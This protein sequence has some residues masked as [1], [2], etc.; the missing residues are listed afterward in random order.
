MFDDI[1]V[2][3][4]MEIMSK[5][6]N[7]WISEE[8]EM[9]DGDYKIIRTSQSGDVYQIHVW[10][11]NEGKM[12]RRSL[13][14]KHLE[15][16]KEKG[17]Q[18]YIKIMSLVNNGK[19]VFSDDVTTVVNR[20]IQYR[21]SDVDTGLIVKGRLTTIHTHLKH[22]LSY[23][24]GDMR[25]SDIHRGTFKE[26]Y[27]FRKKESNNTVNDDT[28]RN[29]YS[30]IR[31]WW[32]YVYDTG[33]TSMTPDQLEFQKFKRERLQND[34]RRDTFTEEEYKKFYTSMRTYCSKKEC[35]TE[36][37]YYNREILRNYTLILSNTGMRTGELDQLKWEDL[38]DYRET[39]FHGQVS[40]IVKIRVRKETSKVRKTRDLFCRESKYFH[41]ISEISK[42]KGNDDFIFCHYDGNVI[43]PRQKSE[44]WNSV[45]KISGIKSEG[46]KLSFYSLRHYFVTQRWKSGV[47]LRD[48][49]NSCGTSVYQLEKTYY[50]IDEETMINTVMYDKRL[51]GKYE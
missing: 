17:K 15:T 27:K 13:R 26:Y 20:F 3:F 24:H 35:K 49:A 30:S 50:H 46:R 1:S 8:H 6:V 29:E 45:I 32:K 14:T 25:V 31:Q 22:M 33:L 39:I 5:R 23:L 16:A 2:F 36:K 47:Q 19:Q 48:I 12:Y 51:K 42:F 28:V 11:S 38:L 9:S 4:W 7:N 37:E 21:Q 34:V 44:F 43:T 41:R 18:E 40:E 10:V